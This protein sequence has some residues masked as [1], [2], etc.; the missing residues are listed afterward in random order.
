MQ[1]K[2]F[3]G[4]Y[5]GEMVNT[6]WVSVYIRPSDIKEQVTQLAVKSKQFQEQMRETATPG[7]S[8][9]TQVTRKKRE[10]D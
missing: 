2:M 4:L 10:F 1:K 7:L 9:D 5:R 6:K 3:L 8:Q